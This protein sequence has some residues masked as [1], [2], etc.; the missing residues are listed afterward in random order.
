MTEKTTPPAEAKLESWKAIAAYLNRDARTVMRWEQSEG[1][2]IH[3]HQHLARSTVYAYPSELDA[4]QAG[5]K[6]DG[7]TADTDQAP[8]RRVSTRLMAAAAVALMTLLSAGGGR[9]MT[10][11]V[12][13][14][15]L[16]AGSLR[17][18]AI[19]A[20]WN[21]AAGPVSA[22]GRYLVY[23]DAAYALAIQDLVAGTDRELVRP[24]DTRR[25]PFPGL[26]RGVAGRAAG[27]LQLVL[28][29][30]IGDDAGVRAVDAR[31]GQP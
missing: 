15:S 9:F 22:D 20:S 5:R 11:D 13:A 29:D 3:R 26:G 6:P 30:G 18:V 28:R 10:A 4:W 19:S 23:I 1:L 31:T 24:L 12:N 16:P 14:A 2:P 27:R 21:Y 25:G 8:P 17:K 7:K